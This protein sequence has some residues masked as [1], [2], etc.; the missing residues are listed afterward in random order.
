[1]NEVNLS[2]RTLSSASSPGFWQLERTTEAARNKV[3]EC[4]GKLG[5]KLIQRS[6]SLVAGSI[7]AAS[8]SLPLPTRTTER[9]AIELPP[10]QEGLRKRIARLGV[11]MAALLPRVGGSSGV[12]PAIKKGTFGAA[13]GVRLPDATVVARGDHESRVFP[14]PASKNAGLIL[15]GMAY[16]RMSRNCAAPGAGFRVALDAAIEVHEYWQSLSEPQK[17]EYITQHAIA[18]STLASPLVS[19]SLNEA[20]GAYFALGARNTSTKVYRGMVDNN[21]LYAAGQPGFEVPAPSFEDAFDMGIPSFSF[22]EDYG[23]A[24]P[25]ERWLTIAGNHSIPLSE[26]LSVG[27]FYFRESIDPMVAI[28]QNPSTF[29]TPD[30]LHQVKN[31]SQ[32]QR[33]IHPRTVPTLLDYS[34]DFAESV[35]HHTNKTVEEEGFLDPD[36]FDYYPEHN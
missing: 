16:E 26:L 21:N 5:D 19:L 17:V 7:S 2:H 4:A 32:I 25:V 11:I 35:K 3:C 23:L 8:G 12:H 20:M 30:D 34:S 22:N 28:K 18:S 14:D 6:G 36:S 29:R 10:T 9:K 24:E 13:E 33:K 31:I 27:G 1:M 15:S